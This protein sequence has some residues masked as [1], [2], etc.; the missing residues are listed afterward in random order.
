MCDATLTMMSQYQTVMGPE[1]KVETTSS[2]KNNQK[3]NEKEE[4][5]KPKKDDENKQ[6]KSSPKTS[7]CMS[8][9]ISSTENSSPKTDS[10]IIEPKTEAPELPED[11]TKNTDNQTCIQSTTENTTE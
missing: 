8:K 3:K 10:D 1:V 2:S 4:E 9:K 11:T 7:C 6:E 5:E